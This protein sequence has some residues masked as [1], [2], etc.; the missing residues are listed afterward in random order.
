MNLDFLSWSGWA[1]VSAI[2]QIIALITLAAALW[3]YILQRRQFPAVLLRWDVIGTGTRGGEGP[4]HAIEFRNIG[5][6]PMIIFLMD[7]FDARPVLDSE[8]RARGVLEAGGSFT[9]LVTAERIEDAWFRV[10]WQTT[11]DR[12]KMH[13]D[14]HPLTQAGTRAEQ[15]ETEVEDWTGL[16]L[17]P[18]KLRERRGEPVAPGGLPYATVFRGTRSTKRVSRIASVLDEHGVSYSALPSARA[19]DDLPY[20]P[21]P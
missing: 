20:F 12:R 2:A 1:G 10:L 14:W 3:R 13:L 5:R 17:V 21:A 9:L 6:A 18:R 15:H 4:F 16:P 19:V 7:V 11:G 8:H